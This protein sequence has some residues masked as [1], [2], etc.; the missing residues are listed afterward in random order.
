MA[1]PLHKI[2]VAESSVARSLFFDLKS[3]NDINFLFWN[4]YL[5]PQVKENGKYHDFVVNELAHF[6][7]RVLVN[8]LALFVFRT[9]DIL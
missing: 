5:L 7:I 6:V 9:E 2:N 4:H 1:F 3:R 8:E